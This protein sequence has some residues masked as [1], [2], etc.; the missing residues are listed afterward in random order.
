MVLDYLPLD[1]N[2]TRE[3]IENSGYID[4]IC[5]DEIICDLID[6]R[7]CKYLYKSGKYEGCMCLRKIRLNKD[8]KDEKEK[9]CHIH[10]YQ[11]K[12]KKKK[13]FIRCS[14]GNCRRRVKEIGLF[15]Y[16][17]KKHDTKIDIYDK[18]VIKL[19]KIENNKVIINEL[20]PYE[21][22]LPKEKLK[23]YI[24]DNFKDKCVLFSKNN[25]NILNEDIKKYILFLNRKNIIYLKIKVF[26]RFNYIFE[27]NRKKIV[28]ND[29]KT[30]TF[31][32]NS[33]K[34]D[35]S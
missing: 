22:P 31:T 34:N 35:K 3:F 24:S 23:I 9:L 2:L 11:K 27:K 6:Y 7:F 21:Y 17:H 25:F 19:E 18:N 20:Y 26:M 14:F 12:K 29:V 13:E 30:S 1:I 4:E 10:R 5:R 33:D 15:C 8:L 16:L 32:N 28:K